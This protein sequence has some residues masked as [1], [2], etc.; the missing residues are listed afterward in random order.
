MRGQVAAFAGVGQ[1]QRKRLRRPAQR[2]GNTHTHRL[3]HTPLFASL[4]CCA[5]APPFLGPWH[6]QASGQRDTCR[7][8]WAERLATAPRARACCFAL[9]ACCTLSFAGDP[10]ATCLCFASAL[11]AKRADGG[12]QLCSTRL[13]DP[14]LWANQKPNAAN[15]AARTLAPYG[16][17]AS[18]RRLVLLSAHKC[19]HTHGAVRYIQHCSHGTTAIGG[20]TYK[21]VKR[22]R[23]DWARGQTECSWMWL[24]HQAAASSTLLY[25]M[26]VLYVY[27]CTHDK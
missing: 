25:C 13:R 3:S 20:C 12:E 16:E 22:M 8:D 5:P 17:R 10:A 7:S 11:P 1:G 26:L 27:Y 6:A 18:I 23:R 24:G 15:V 19:S 4:L 21:L 9:H 2:L 14:A